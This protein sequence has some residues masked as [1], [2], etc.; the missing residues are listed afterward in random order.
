M[1]AR[2]HTH[3]RMAG[4]VLQQ[5]D[6]GV[7]IEQDARRARDGFQQAALAL[8]PGKGLA[9]FG[10][11]HH[12]AHFVGQ[13][14]LHRIDGWRRIRGRGGDIVRAGQVDAQMLRRLL[15]LAR[16]AAGQVFQYLQLQRA[17]LRR[18]RNRFPIVGMAA[19][20]VRQAHDADQGMTGLQARQRFMVIQHAVGQEGIE[21]PA[22]D[23]PGAR[24][25]M[26]D[27][28]GA[29]LHSAQGGIV[30]RREIERVF[31]RRRGQ[32]GQ[33]A[34]VVQQA[35]Q[36]RFLDVR[37]GHGLGQRARHDGDRQR[38]FPE[39]AQIR[40]AGMGKAVEGLED[41]FADDQG[42]DHVRAQRHERLFQAD[43]LALA[44]VGR[45][46]GHAEDLAAHA[47][48]PGD[49][50]GQ[51]RHAGIVGLQVGD[52]FDEDLRHGRQAGNQ[53]AIANILIRLLHRI[54]HCR[55]EKDER[56]AAKRG[57]VQRNPPLL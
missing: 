10:Y 29:L 40:A 44:M 33:A 51:L 55:F 46:V 16:D 42:L 8:L 57:H 50:G 43:D 15:H 53:Q 27:L 38:A 4:G 2:R 45:A 34:H 6:G 36:I 20:Q 5:D 13:A 54:R 17:K 7:E 48:I 22:L 25:G 56:S 21:L 3:Q 37:I 24:F 26:R 23:Q 31:L 30:A 14:L 39:G 11:Q 19:Q 32:Q 47:R 28:Q 18:L 9:H 49:Q 35:C 41:R 1:F 52:Q 12:V